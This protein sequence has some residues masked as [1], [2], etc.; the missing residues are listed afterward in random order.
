MYQP[1]WVST[2]GKLMLCSHRALFFASVHRLFFVVSGSDAFVCRFYAT[3]SRNGW[4]WAYC[5]PLG[6]T[7]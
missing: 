1:S 2:R 4:G 5:L 7:L 6:L 3:E